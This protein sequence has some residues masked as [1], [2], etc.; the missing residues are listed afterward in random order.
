MNPN[1]EMAEMNAAD[2]LVQMAATYRERNALYG[3]NYKE[4]GLIMEAIFP[5]EILLSTPDDFNRFALLV[6]IVAKVTRYAKNFH[7]GG[8]ID[9]IHDVGVYAAMLEELTLIEKL[10]QQSS[11]Q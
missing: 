10:A 9:S 7:S 2:L 1:K 5:N 3:N 8:H 11:A 6:Q 4:F